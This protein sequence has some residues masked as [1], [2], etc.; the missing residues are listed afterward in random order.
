MLGSL[1][2]THTIRTTTPLVNKEGNE[3]GPG[4]YLIRS[5]DNNNNTRITYMPSGSFQTFQLRP[6][7]IK[8]VF[9]EDRHDAVLVAIKVEATEV[10]SIWWGAYFPTT[11]YEFHIPKDGLEP[12]LSLKV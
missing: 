5:V 1:V 7:Q 4:I 11:T 8:N 12:M 9:F 3:T 10:S 6:D 2:P